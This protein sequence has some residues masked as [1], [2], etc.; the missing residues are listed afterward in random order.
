MR[1]LTRLSVSAL[2]LALSLG[3]AWA[4]VFGV[5]NPAAFT[6]TIDWCA[7]YGCN[8]QTP[9]NPSPWT[10][11]GGQTG[12]VG[13]NGTN[14]SFYVLQQ[15]VS[16][17][18]GFPAGMGLIYNGAI[19]NA[20]AGAPIDLIFNNGVSGVGAYIQT[21]YYGAFTASLTLYDS[22]FNV[23]GTVTAADT[24]TGAPGSALFLGA[25]DSNWSAE[26]VYAAEF[27]ASGVGP[28]EPDF[29]IGS[30]MTTTGAPEPA[31]FALIGLGLLGVGW[32]L[33]RRA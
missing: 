33:R 5:S 17:F 18:E 14:D 4:G 20:S 7:N 16:A 9:G 25:I 21:D 27:S 1:L 31:S 3:S 8:V 13:L 10:S 24:M 26:E 30:G 6:D 15:G 12:L 29:L 22:S 32:K 19:F 28:Y 11:A 23:L 2:G